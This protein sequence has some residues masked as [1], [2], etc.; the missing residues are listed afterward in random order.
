MEPC[1]SYAG[2]A[3][4]CLLVTVPVQHLVRVRDRLGVGVGIRGWG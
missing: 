1:V 4:M 3:P 2:V